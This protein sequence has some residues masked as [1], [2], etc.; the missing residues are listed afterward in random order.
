MNYLKM[1]R[2]LMPYFLIA[3]FAPLF[4]FLEVQMNLLIP[5]TMEKVVDLGIVSGKIDRILYY[6]GYM[7]LYAFLGILFA[8]TSNFFATW[9]SSKMVHDIRVDTFR[10]ALTMSFSS[11]DELQT[12]EVITRA[13]SDVNRLRWVTRVSL[14]LFFRAPMMLVGALIMAYRKSKNLSV[15]FLIII[16]LIALTNWLIIRKAAPLFRKMQ[17][18][19]EAVNTFTHEI[20]KNIRVVKA[21]NRGDYAIGQFDVKIDELKETTERAHFITLFNYPITS[22]IINLSIVAILYFGGREVI[23]QHGTDAASLSLGR[24]IAFINYLWQVVNSIMMFNRIINLY[25]QAEASSK[26]L[27]EL[28]ETDYTMSSQNLVTADSGH[29]FKGEITFKNVSFSYD[30]KK[31]VLDRISFTVKPGQR[32]GI[33]G[34]TG[35][36][37]STL[38]SLIP[39][40]YDATEGEVLI[41]GINVKDYDLHYLRSNISMVMQRP[42]LFS[43]TIGDNV[44]FARMDADEEEMI[45]ATQI[46]DA[47]EFIVRY[48]DRFD[49][50]IGQRGINLSGGQKQR[51]SMARSIITEPKILIF[52]DSTSAVDMQTEARILSALQKKTKGTTT[53]II[54]QRIQSIIDCD[55]IL[56]LEDGKITGL[57]TH[58]ELLKTNELYR[59]I[60][61]IQIGSDGDA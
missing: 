1:L 2:Y 26:R 40:Y 8:L 16:P 39:R 51:I 43:G 17:E 45:Q 48:P 27:L 22:T 21:F 10:K 19:L 44:R 25:P 46:A 5:D 55:Q 53:I 24:I 58:E 52:D 14:R 59:K 20:L 31:K 13:T 54:A 30:G 42:L 38:I 29:E 32:L 47:Y 12:G 33:I 28:L 15:V 18:K 6:G 7:L 9:A 36:G 49:S 60:Y 34:T 23:A 50:I 4:L 41:D 37:K 3:I 35:A 57:G 61:E 11:L 56:V